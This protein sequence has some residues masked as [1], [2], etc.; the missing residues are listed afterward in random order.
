MSDY[1]IRD[2]F[3]GEYETHF[4]N[5]DEEGSF[6][7]TLCGETSKQNCYPNHLENGAGWYRMVCIVDCEEDRSGVEAFEFVCPVEDASTPEEAQTIYE[8][9]L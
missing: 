2:L 8:N 6:D 5:V 9:S 1:N 3:N 7:V 4:V